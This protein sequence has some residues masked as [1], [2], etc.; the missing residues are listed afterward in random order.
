[1]AKRESPCCTSPWLSDVV[2]VLQTKLTCS[3]T[4]K[5]TLENSSST[6][7]DFLKL[8]FD[9]SATRAAQAI[10]SEGELTSEQA[11][12]LEWDIVNRPV[13]S[14][15]ADE[16]MSILPG[17]RMTVTVTCL[18]KVGWSVDSLVYIVKS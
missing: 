13:F 12:E 17:G 11:Y 9:D 10:L 4:I 3:S 1:M 7:V 8:S 14:W 2:A 15:K 16:D 6:T 18:G 5:I